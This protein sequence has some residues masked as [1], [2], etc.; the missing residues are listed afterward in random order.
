MK[1]F[2]KTIIAAGLVIVAGTVCALPNPE[3]EVLSAALRARNAGNLA[4]AKHHLEQLLLLKPS[5]TN[6][7]LLLAGVN[8]DIEKSLVVRESANPGKSEQE[9]DVVGIQPT[10]NVLEHMPEIETNKA[11]DVDDTQTGKPE[12]PVTTRVITKAEMLRE[13]DSDWQRPTLYSKTAAR[14][15]TTRAIPQNDKL[16]T[17]VLP[18]VSFSGEGLSSVVDKLSA[19]TEENDPERQ[20]VNL[21]LINSQEVEPLVNITL[22]QLTLERVLDFITDAVGYEY[23]VMADGVILRKAAVEGPRLETEFYSLS[24]STLLR[25][26]GIEPTQKTQ[27]A[28]PFQQKTTAVAESE[29]PG[30]EKALKQF[31]QRAGVPFDGIAGANLALADGQLIVTQTTRNLQR[32]ENILTR[33]EQVKQVEIETRFIEVQQGDLEELGFDWL[34][35]TGGQNTFD[36]LTG[37]PIIT[38]TGDIQQS[39]SRT[40]S[41]GRESGVRSLSDAFGGGNQ[42]GD[43]LIITGTQADGKIVTTVD[44]VMGPRLPGGID[45]AVGAVAPFADIG[46]VIGDFDVNVMIRALSRKQGT[47]L[48]SAP[49]ITVLSGKT[50]EIV[51]AKELR[52]PQRYSDINAQVGRGSS[53][54]G[55]AGVAITAGTPQDFTTR[56]VGVE[57]KVTPTVEDNDA[58]HLTLTPEVTEFEGY[59][60]YGG[61][62]IAIASNTT[63]KVPSGFFQPI[64]SVRRV[65]TEVTIWDGA[66]VV[67][68]GLTRE[69]NIS[70]HD[71]VPLLG[72]LPLLGRLFQSRGESTEKRN[73]LIFV[74]ATLVNPGGAPARQR[75]VSYAIP[76]MSQPAP[77]QPPE[78]NQKAS[79]RK[80]TRVKK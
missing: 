17:I 47:D 65:K 75:P 13:V 41:S 28:D 76:E 21:I 53:T 43:N 18:R 5:D 29:S 79:N 11:M 73:L 12:Q 50:A 23:E 67:M 77:V 36:P 35:R 37:N 38:P 9:Q 22:R 60:E 33:Y 70:V 62:S 32:I 72:D 55:S 14:E 1:L 27:K 48:M 49:K 46:G 59:V 19:M 66:T 69:Q 44:G 54:A 57:M 74:T 39:Y 26:T 45:T 30:N 34:V 16:K 3:L 31:F 20:G 8:V 71:K 63:V 10:L 40:F 78:D 56:N 4:E 80:Y 61:P 6:A 7:Q 25:I 42:M 24:Q 2:A 52:Y 64:F 51:V 58:I 68:G 15:H